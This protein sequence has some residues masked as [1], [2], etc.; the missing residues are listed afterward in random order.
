[1]FLF[2]NFK[3]F[4]K[5]HPKYYSTGSRASGAQSDQDR[6]R[7]GGQDR[8]PQGEQDGNPQGDQNRSPQELTVRWRG[9]R[10][11]ANDPSNSGAK[12]FAHCPIR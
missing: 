6:I 11:K 2:V 4:L 8:N 3:L 7:Q 5:P 1:M 12:G 9:L 10:A